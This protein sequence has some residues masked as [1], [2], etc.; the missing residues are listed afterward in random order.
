M[1]YS[2]AFIY[3]I[4]FLYRVLLLTN[5]VIK[6]GILIASLISKY[7]GRSCLTYDQR[8]VP[9]VIKLCRPSYSI[10]TSYQIL[11]M[12]NRVGITF[13]SGAQEFIPGIWLGIVLLSFQFSI[14]EL[15]FAMFFSFTKNLLFSV[16]LLL[17]KKS[18]YDFSI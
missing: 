11:N 2:T 10:V 14:C 16:G 15:C 12:G 7:L 1:R 17:L 6:Q 5:K 13:P 9:Y 18:W 3:Y 4:Y 8:S